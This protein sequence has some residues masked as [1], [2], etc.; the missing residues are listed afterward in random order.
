MKKLSLLAAA[1]LALTGCAGLAYGSRPVTGNIGVIG[2][3]SAG[4]AVTNNTVGSKTGTACSESILGIVT[5]GDAS[6][7][8][9]AKNG[10]IKKI[11]TVD[12]TYKQIMGFYAKYCVVVTGE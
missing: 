1:A 5:K 2:E 7:A 4:E 6:Y 3:T 11:F 10:N 8:T 9:A 12:N